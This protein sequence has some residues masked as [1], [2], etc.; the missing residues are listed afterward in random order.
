MDFHVG[1]PVVHSTYGLGQIV[2]LEERALAGQKKLYYFVQIQN[3]TVCVPADDKAENRLR[4]PT[5]KAA[6][7]KLFT[8]LSGPSKPLSGDRHERKIQLRKDLADGDVETVC[9]VIRDLSSYGQRKPLNDDDKNILKRAWGSLRG[10]WGFS[11]SVPPAE[12]DI[13]IHRLLNHTVEN[14]IG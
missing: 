14:A 1:D 3:L 6:F 5:P 12:V 9:R 2:D 7:K 4:R 13:E 10:E 8:I 11:L